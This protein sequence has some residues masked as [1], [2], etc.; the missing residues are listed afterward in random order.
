MCPLEEYMTPSPLDYSWFG[1]RQARQ[2]G[3]HLENLRVV[4]MEILIEGPTCY[5]SVVICT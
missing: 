5:T 2:Q 4:T 3:K 1:A